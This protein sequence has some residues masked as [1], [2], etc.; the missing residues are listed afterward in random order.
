M[1]TFLP[2]L[3]FAPSGKQV[4]SQLADFYGLGLRERLLSP[5]VFPLNGPTKCLGGKGHN[6]QVTDICFLII[7]FPSFFQEVW[8]GVSHSTTLKGP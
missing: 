8:E 6:S 1:A 3:P 5:N 4:H 7:C 2:L